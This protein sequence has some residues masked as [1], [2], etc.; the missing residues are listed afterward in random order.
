MASGDLAPVWWMLDVPSAGRL[1]SRVSTPRTWPP[2]RTIKQ[3][4][5]NLNGLPD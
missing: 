2:A 1:A 3:H 5:P 4:L